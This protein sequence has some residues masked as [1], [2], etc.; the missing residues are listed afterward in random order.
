MVSPSSRRRTVKY[1]VEE[2]LSNAAQ[3]CRALGLAHSSFYLG[4]AEEAQ[5]SK[6]EPENRVT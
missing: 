3:G 4:I 6:A 2:G 5:Q 1:L